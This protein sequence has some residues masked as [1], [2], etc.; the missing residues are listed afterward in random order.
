MAVQAVETCE[1]GCAGLC[2]SSCIVIHGGM[3][4]ALSVHVACSLQ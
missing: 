4:S 2:A 3:S 1:R